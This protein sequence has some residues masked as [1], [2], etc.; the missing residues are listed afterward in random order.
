MVTIAEHFATALTNNVSPAEL[1]RQSRFDHAFRRYR[2]WARDNKVK[3]KVRHKFRAK[4]WVKKG[5]PQIGQKV[6]NAAA[7]RTML[8]WMHDVC[9]QHTDKPSDR[10]RAGML[11]HF[12]RADMVCRR[13]GRFF[14]ADEQQAY[15]GHTE[16][17]LLLCNLL[18]TRATAK[19]QK[20]YK[21]VPKFHALT[22]IAYDFDKTG[23]VNPRRVSCYQ[24]ED[25]GQPQSTQGPT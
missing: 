25:M 23:C 15:S 3:T 16:K 14:S 21:L 8:Y 4:Q 18:A 20:L 11:G 19:N 1:S 17:A 24:D 13:A 7:T 9:R 12:V 22:H 2:R 10:M 5:W 6:A